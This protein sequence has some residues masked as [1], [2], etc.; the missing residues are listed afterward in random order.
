MTNGSRMPACFTVEGTLEKVDQDY[1]F[2][3][4]PSE[5]GPCS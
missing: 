4:D 2:D 5:P 3:P 1:L